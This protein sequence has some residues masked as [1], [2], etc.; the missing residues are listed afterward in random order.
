MLP[1]LTA[2]YKFIS[3]FFKATTPCCAIGLVEVEG[4]LTSLLSLRLND[5]V[6]TTGWGFNFGNC[7][8]GTSKYEVVLFS[9]EFYGFNNYNVLINPNNPI[10]RKVLSIMI[11]TGDFFMFLFNSENSLTAFRS[12]IN[13]NCLWGLKDN[14]S[15]IEQS[16][17][18]EEEY[19]QTLSSFKENPYPKGDMLNW[20]CNDD[21][22]YIDLFKYRFDLNPSK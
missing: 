10:S 20:V 7:L 3:N 11:E 2:N 4:K 13:E 9:F 17:T 19:L 6:P 18:T 21:I 8:L 15:R 1:K 22:E 16:S 12:E 14:F 5:N